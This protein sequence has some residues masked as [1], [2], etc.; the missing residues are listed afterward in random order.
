MARKVSRIDGSGV[1]LGGEYGRSDGRTRQPTL[2]FPKLGGM[3]GFAPLRR[4]IR[5]MSV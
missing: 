4:P 1:A 3:I 5:G 2:V